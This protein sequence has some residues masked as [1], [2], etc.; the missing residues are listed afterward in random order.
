[1]IRW[2]KHNQMLQWTLAQ[3]ATTEILFHPGS[4]NWAS[5]GVCNA[6]ERCDSTFAVREGVLQCVIE[7]PDYVTHP[8]WIVEADVSPQKEVNEF[9]GQPA[10]GPE[11]TQDL[12]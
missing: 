8:N 6:R 10:L 3:A 9:D 7:R 12:G 4:D 5:R 11:G 2:R 1:V